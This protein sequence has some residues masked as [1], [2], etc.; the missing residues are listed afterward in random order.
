MNVE[1]STK[2]TTYLEFIEKEKTGISFN[3]DP[4][5][6]AKAPNGGKCPHCKDGYLYWHRETNYATYY[7][8][9]KCGSEVKV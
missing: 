6:N 3:F 2:T 1:L 9:G 4:I 8:C 5:Q 7:K